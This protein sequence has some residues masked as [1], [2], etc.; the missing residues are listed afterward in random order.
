[1]LMLGEGVLFVTRAAMPMPMLAT[2]SKR[3][4]GMVS[5]PLVL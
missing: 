2:K 1:M 5:R 3:S 4:G